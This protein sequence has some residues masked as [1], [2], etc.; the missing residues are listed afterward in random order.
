MSKDHLIRMAGRIHRHLSSPSASIHSEWHRAASELLARSQKMQRDWELA[1]Q[2]AEHGWHAAAA[3][4]EQDVQSEAARIEAAASILVNQPMRPP[5]QSN[6]PLL[7]TIV[8]ELQQLED[9]FES[10]E[11]DLKEGLVGVTTPPIVL[12]EIHL[13]PFSIELHVNRLSD[14]LG[15]ECFNC[16]SLEPNPAASR[17]DTTHPHVQD[18]HICAGDANLPV[19]AALKEGRIADAFLLI[20][21]VL[22]NY[23]EDSPY[24]SLENWS[25]RRCD[26]CDYVVDSDSL[27]FCEGCERDICEDCYSSCDMCDS[28][29]CRSCLETDTV[30]GNR[31]CSACRHTCSECQRTVD[32]ESFDE[33]TE[34][35]PGCLEKQKQQEETEHEHESESI[36]PAVAAATP[37]G[38]PAAA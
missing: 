5:A 36:K 26:D 19:T 33:E 34:L 16:I 28:G 11:I 7:G 37:I 30:S 27:C 1:R 20:Q 32:S 18:G 35:C 10:F 15:S 6:P 25:G 9:E 29:C 4:K 38:V 14:R 17:E 31:C 2:A 24:I 8:A 23:N 21:S 12:E 22:Q 13:G 3:V